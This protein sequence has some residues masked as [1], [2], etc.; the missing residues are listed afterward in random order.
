MNTY[1]KL[2]ASGAVYPSLD[3][4]G[5][6]LAMIPRWQILNPPL[7][8]FMASLR[9]LPAMLAL[10][11]PL[12]MRWQQVDRLTC[13]ISFIIEVELAFSQF[14]FIIQAKQ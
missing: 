5:G 6:A 2:P 4:D 1:K 8:H 7:H 14:V 3:L 11:A 13:F 9:S 12:I 10:R